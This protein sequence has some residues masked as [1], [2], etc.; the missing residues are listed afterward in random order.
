M[1]LNKRNARLIKDV[2]ID[3]KEKKLLSEEKSTELLNNIKVISFDYKKLS[4]WSFI[5]SILCF[6]IALTNVYELMLQYTMVR[7]F[8]S[9]FLSSIFFYFGFKNKKYEKRL[10]SEFFIF[11]GVLFIAWF[12]AEI[13]AYGFLKN[14][15]NLLFFLSGILY[16]IIAYFGSS[17]LVLIFSIIS[18]GNWF[19]CGLGYISGQGSYF[20]YMLKPLNF[21]FFGSFLICISYIIRIINFKKTKIFFKT[22]LSL[23]LLYVFVSMWIL[24]IFGN[25]IFLTN[26]K[27]IE[28]L[29]WSLL[30]LLFSLISVYLGLKYDS[31]LLKGYGI[32]FFMINLYTKYFEYFWNITNKTIFFVILSLSFYFIAKK[33]ENIYLILEKKFGKLNK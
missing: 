15:F 30:F 23:G 2:I 32:T 20:L 7:I 3:F 22:F 14:H 17:N 11:I 12:I 26:V 21:V 9:I 24:S 28:L 13:S 10:S 8:V 5:F 16:A 31:Y 19:G 18:L 33:S 27:E 1:Q 25:N 6:F 29:F 4:K